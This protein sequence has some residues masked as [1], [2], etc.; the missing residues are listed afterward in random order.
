VTFAH[1][2]IAKVFT[3]AGVAPPDV[4]RKPES[5]Y[6]RKRSDQQFARRVALTKRKHDQRDDSEPRAPKDVHDARVPHSKAD[7]PEHKHH[8]HRNP[9]R[10]QQDGRRVFQF[11]S[12]ILVSGFWF[13]ISGFWF[14]VRGNRKP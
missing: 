14:L 4:S 7:K 9:E 13:L 10:R 11:S 2:L 1:R 5:P 3:L 6:R 8:H 12:L